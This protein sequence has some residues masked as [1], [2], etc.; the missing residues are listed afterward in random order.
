MS[1]HA[2][3]PV[4]IAIIA[5]VA[6]ASVTTACAP[7]TY[8]ASLAS[9][10][11]VP[12]TTTE[13]S[14]TVEELLERLSLAMGE[15]S[16]FI[17]PDQSG[18]TPVGKSDQLNLIESLWAAVEGPVLAADEAAADSLARMVALSRTA[19]ERNRPADADKAS[20]FAGQVIQDFLR[21]NA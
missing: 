8:D 6:T 18:R 10:T 3:R 7:T 9:S 2:R 16:R 4:T 15:L 21:T 11:T 12:P 5:L 1:M 17:G 14:G 19:V 20:R 13:P